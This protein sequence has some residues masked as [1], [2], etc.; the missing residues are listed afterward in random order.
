MTKGLVY[1]VTYNNAAWRSALPVIKIGATADIHKRLIALSVASPIKLLIAGT[2]A[3]KDPYPLE[4]S[5]HRAFVR[6]NLNGEWFK[7]TKGMLSIIRTYI[8]IDDRFDELFNF[9]DL[10][11]DAKDLQ[12]LSLQNEIKQLQAKLPPKTNGHEICNNC[13]L[14]LKT[15]VT[16]YSICPRCFRTFEDGVCTGYTHRKRGWNVAF[17]TPK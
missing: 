9:S 6:E 10:K 2:I 8:I 13:K 5:F 14:P 16:G 7:L 4:R 17:K 12:I 11:P 15:D 1:F 3:S